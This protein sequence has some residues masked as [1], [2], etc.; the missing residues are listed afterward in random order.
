MQIAA[1]APF[2][3]L[4]ASILPPPPS[5]P[6]LF[7]YKKLFYKDC[8]VSMGSEVE[9]GTAVVI[10]IY[11][12][13]TGISVSLTC[14]SS[15]WIPVQSCIYST[16]LCWSGMAP[17]QEAELITEPLRCAAEKLHH[18]CEKLR[19]RRLLLRG[20]CFLCCPQESNFGC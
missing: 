13:Y 9:E 17:L 20:F 5:H 11:H 12:S 1:S 3:P 10:S 19:V 15:D 8:W 6:M 18:F 7:L 2:L 14:L 16:C 4:N